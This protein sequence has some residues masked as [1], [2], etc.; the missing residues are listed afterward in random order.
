MTNR[1][2]TSNDH[3]RAIVGRTRPIFPRNFAPRCALRNAV[4]R[5]VEL[6]SETVVGQRSSNPFSPS[7]TVATPNP[8]EVG[9]PG[10]QVSPFA[11]PA[12]SAGIDVVVD[13]MRVS[14]DD[15]TYEDAA[16]SRQDLLKRAAELGPAR[17]T[18]ENIVLAPTDPILGE[19]MQPRVAER[20]AR[21]R[22][23]VKV[24]L[25]ACVAFCLVA[26]VASAVSSTSSSSSSSAT[27]SALKTAPASGVVPV[28]K[29]EVVL[30]TKAPSKVTAAVRPRAPKKRR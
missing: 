11:A 2:S 3:P 30:R 10:P 1:R 27:S 4:T 5:G 18:W 28:E 20:R 19:K 16:P 6:A 22:K 12:P 26:T 13:D 24:A 29:L 15:A 21:F 23:I 14:P 9:A 7:A 8:F 25:G 17:M